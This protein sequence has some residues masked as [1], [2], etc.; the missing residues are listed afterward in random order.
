MGSGRTWKPPAPKLV[1]IGEFLGQDSK[2]RPGP[3]VG[4]VRVLCTHSR[5]WTVHQWFGTVKLTADQERALVPA[6]NMCFYP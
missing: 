3:L 4:P 5:G 2:V 6:K 1:F